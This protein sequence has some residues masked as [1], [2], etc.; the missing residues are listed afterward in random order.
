[1]LGPA[2]TLISVHFSHYTHQRKAIYYLLNGSFYSV[3]EKSYFR[4]YWFILIAS[5]LVLWKTA[6][7]MTIVLKKIKKGCCSFYHSRQQTFPAEDKYDPCMTQRSQY[8]PG[9]CLASNPDTTQQ[10]LG[11][12]VLETAVFR[13][14]FQQSD[15]RNTQL[16][17]HLVLTPKAAV[18]P[19][20]RDCISDSSPTERLSPLKFFDSDKTRQF[21]RFTHTREESKALSC[22]FPTHCRHAGIHR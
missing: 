2:W 21:L 20:R 3:A 11:T 22:P 1:M 14:D 8:K 9:T 18:V 17:H 7:A 6:I 15:I 12:H 4:S 19:C 13:M 5:I 10:P 16:C